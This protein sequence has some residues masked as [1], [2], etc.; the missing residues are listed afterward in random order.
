MKRK[1]AIAFPEVPFFSGGAE[2]LVKTL[3][4]K[5][6]QRGYHAEIITLPFKWYPVQQLWEQMLLWKTIDL[7]ETDG[8]K[9]D[10]VIGT[11]WPSYLTKHDNKIIWL[12]H[13][14]REAYD[15][16]NI[17]FSHFRTNGSAYPYLQQFRD[18][19]TAAITE[20]KKIFT[21][22]KNVS[23]RLNHFNGVES[24]VLYHPP[25]GR[26]KYYS[27][28]FG[29][30]ILSVGRLSDLKRL[31]LLI[32]AMKYTNPSVKCLIAGTGTENCKKSLEALIEKNNLK[33][34]VKLL[35]FISEEEVLQLYSESLAVYF[36]PKDED[37]GAITLE[38]FFSKKPII[39]TVDSGGVLEFAESGISAMI[40]EAHAEQI[41][42]SI[43]Y[44]W[45][46][47]KLAQEFG[48]NGYEKVKDISWDNVLDCLLSSGG[49]L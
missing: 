15:L 49:L 23:S 48:M 21:I 8:E 45:S 38:A 16:Q 10:L 2:I 18:A 7:S 11:K 28:K 1:I 46:N 41:G 32:L 29:D 40:T 36:A 34:R 42:E 25:R 17:D 33:S 35:G 27:G 19:D 5:L 30:Y 24:E 13:Q 12:I 14:H 43:N 31:D 4:D 39:T 26:E 20:S 9:I 37:Y 22:S 3:R 6:N 47:K 44:L